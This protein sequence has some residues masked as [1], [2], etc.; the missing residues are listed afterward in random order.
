[1]SAADIFSDWKKE[2]GAFAGFSNAWNDAAELTLA[3]RGG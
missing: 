3:F 2:F 1:M